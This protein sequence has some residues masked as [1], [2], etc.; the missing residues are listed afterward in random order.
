[1]EKQLE[2]EHFHCLSSYVPSKLRWSFGREIVQVV[3]SQDTL[4]AKAGH[5]E[6]CAQITAS[7][8][9]TSAIKSWEHASYILKMLA[10]GADLSV[11]S[12]LVDTTGCMQLII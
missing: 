6:C 11:V 9:E 2:L 4:E 5:E 3:L 8:S 1:M 7:Q 12:L 10:L